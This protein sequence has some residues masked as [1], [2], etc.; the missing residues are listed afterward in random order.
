VDEMATTDGEDFSDTETA[1]DSP[2]LNILCRPPPPTHYTS[3][4]VPAAT[5]STDFPDIPTR[6]ILRKGMHLPPP[7]SPLLTEAL[8]DL[9]QHGILTPYRGCFLQPKHQEPL[10]RYWTLHYDPPHIQ[11]YSAAKVLSTIPRN[12]WMIK[13][14]LKSG[15]LQIPIQE[16]Y[17][18]YYGV[19][20]QKQGP[21]WTSLPMGH[22]LAPSI[23]QRF[24]TTI[25]C[26]LFSFQMSSNNDSLSE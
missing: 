9:L 18:K 21:A 15:F 5:F 20:Y 24:S 16:Q 11:L 2:Q 13:V 4:A 23:M 10:D 6:E 3:V 22:S 26:P 7:R 1:S 8:Q 25:D 12:S 14:I 19:Y 17:Y